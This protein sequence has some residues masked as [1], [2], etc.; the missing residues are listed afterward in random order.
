MDNLQALLSAL[1]QDTLPLPLI[2]EAAAVFLAVLLAWVVAWLLGRR[3]SHP[4]VLFGEKV[5]EE[6][7]FRQLLLGQHI[8]GPYR[9]LVTLHAVRDGVVE[10]KI[11]LIVSNVAWIHVDLDRVCECIGF[12]MPDKRRIKLCLH[13]LHDELTHLLTNFVLFVWLSQHLHDLAHQPGLCA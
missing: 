2:K 13:Q 11:S 6:F 7:S 4:S 9:D 1:T 12:G 8:A 3:V 5:I 10:L